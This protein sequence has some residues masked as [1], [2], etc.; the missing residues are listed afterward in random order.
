MLD[1]KE[2]SSHSISEAAD[3]VPEQLIFKTPT[4]YR[5]RSVTVLTPS[6]C[7]MN[8]T[9]ASTPAKDVALDKWLEGRGEPAASYQHLKQID[10]ENKE[11]YEGEV[12]QSKNASYEDLKIPETG[13]QTL[14]IRDVEVDA[15]EA[16]E[17]LFKLIIDVSIL[18]FFIL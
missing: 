2:D 5:R 15:K 12:D 8:P 17:D 9:Y 10:D 13:E 14:P 3:V 4:A 16:L 6:T 1:I 7:T 11:N 18:M